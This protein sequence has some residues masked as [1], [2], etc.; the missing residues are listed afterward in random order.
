VTADESLQ[1]APAF[2]IAKFLTTRVS[3]FLYNDDDFSVEKDEAVCLA[4]MQDL[5]SQDPFG[6]T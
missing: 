5:F 1:L 4:M 3:S 6:G 2:G